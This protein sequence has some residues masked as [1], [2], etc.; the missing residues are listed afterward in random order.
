MSRKS[1][2]WESSRDT[3]KLIIAFHNFG[4]AA[5]NCYKIRTSSTKL[6]QERKLYRRPKF[7]TAN[8]YVHVIHRNLP[9]FLVILPP[10]SSGREAIGASA[11]LVYVYETGEAT[12]YRTAL[13]IVTVM[14]ISKCHVILFCESFLL[15]NLPSWAQNVP[16]TSAKAL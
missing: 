16:V 1:V 10:A 8:I 11:K 15:N 4:K 3:T 13:Y 14:R 2:L 7:K 6:R 9:A 5:K 12:F